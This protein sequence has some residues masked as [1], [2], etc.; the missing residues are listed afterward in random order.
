MQPRPVNLKPGALIS[1]AI[2][3]G[4][5]VFVSGHVGWVPETREAPAGIEAQTAQ[6]LENL[7]AVLEAAGT[8]LEHVVKVNI[9]LTSIA[10]DFA[11]MNQVFRRY[12]PKNPPARTT[13]GVAALAR[14][15]L[16]IEIEMVA[17]LPDVGT[18]GP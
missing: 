2:V 17:L 9:F 16:L 8:L 3:A 5:L 1:P 10:D 15:D 11:A 18:L 7:K 6:A 4:N 14:P 13:V 12:F